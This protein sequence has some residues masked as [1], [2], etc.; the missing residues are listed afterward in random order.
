MAANRMR[1]LI[2]LSIWVLLLPL[3]GCAVSPEPAVNRSEA[4]PARHITLIWKWQPTFG[5]DWSNVVF[6]VY[7][8]T[9]LND[10]WE[11]GATVDTNRYEDWD[12]RPP[13]RFYTVTASNTITG[14]EAPKLK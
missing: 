8:R 5:H 9:M 11:L 4:F 14:E 6:N 7:Q 3:T 10:A 12:A 13:S 1:M 2:P